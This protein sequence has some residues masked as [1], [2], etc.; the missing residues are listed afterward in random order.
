M[1]RRPATWAR[2]WC[3]GS[4]EIAV[5]TAIATAATL[6]LLA[7]HFGR[8]SLIALPANLLVAPAFPFIFL[9]S[10]LTGAVGAAST[11]AGEVVGWMTAWLPLSWF[12]EVAE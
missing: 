11:T 8:I 2:E 7:L 5:V 12:V 4:W 10:L 1:E 6:P 3:R 9:G